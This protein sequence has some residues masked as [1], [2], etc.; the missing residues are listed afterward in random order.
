MPI[1]ESTPLT[2]EAIH[3][4]GHAVVA[5]ALGVP[6]RMVNLKHFAS[7]ADPGSISYAW[8]QAGSGRDF[9]KATLAFVLMAMAGCVAEEDFEMQNSK[10]DANNVWRGVMTMWP[11]RPMDFYAARLRGLCRCVMR[12]IAKH[13]DKIETLAVALAERGE[14][15]AQDVGELLGVAIV[16][17]PA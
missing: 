5:A 4:A 9:R 14:L 3:E 16:R 6:F 15:S 8:D 12:I 7:A 11:D 13:R 17:V 2:P 1:D 10:A